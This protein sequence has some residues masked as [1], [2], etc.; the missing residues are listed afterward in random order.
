ML[1]KTQKSQNFSKN[2]TKYLSQKKGIV[3]NENCSS[4]WEH[5]PTAVLDSILSLVI[6]QFYPN[7]LKITLKLGQSFKYKFEKNA[8][9]KVVHLHDYIPKINQFSKI[10]SKLPLN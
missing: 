6:A 7:R 9:I 1:N 2:Y 10:G 5:T 4:I 8:K 3:E